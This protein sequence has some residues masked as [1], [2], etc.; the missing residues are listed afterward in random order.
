MSLRCRRPSTHF[1]SPAAGGGEQVRAAVVGIDAAL[2]EPGVDERRDLP[3][4]RRRVRAQRLRDL[5]DALRALLQQ[6][7][8]YEVSAWWRCRARTRSRRARS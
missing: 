7:A 6:Q 3:A 4:H 1:C 2:H 5:P 8:Q